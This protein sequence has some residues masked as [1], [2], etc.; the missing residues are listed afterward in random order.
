MNWYFV[1]MRLRSVLVWSYKQYTGGAQR[2][3]C[4][5]WLHIP[6]FWD[7]GTCS[8]KAKC[9]CHCRLWVL[10]AP[11]RARFRIDSHPPVWASHCQPK[12]WKWRACPGEQFVRELYCGSES[13]PGIHSKQ[14]CWEW[15]VTLPHQEL[16]R[17]CKNLQPGRT[18]LRTTHSTLVKP[19]PRSKD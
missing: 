8:R 3:Q 11:V 7:E 2:H 6:A 4:F 14:A 17:K 16:Y 19:S 5:S 15:W 10:V 13:N 9:H 12:S 18:L 1:S